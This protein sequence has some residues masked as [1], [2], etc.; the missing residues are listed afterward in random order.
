MFHTN[1]FRTT[2][3]REVEVS[4]AAVF[5]PQAPKA[6]RGVRVLESAEAR[7]G[8]F[9]QLLDAGKKFDPDE[10]AKVHIVGFERAIR[11]VI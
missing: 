11:A 2:E 9:E 8:R 7:W 10:L 1:H 3:M 4:P 5:G 6:I